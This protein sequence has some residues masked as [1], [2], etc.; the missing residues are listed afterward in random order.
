MKCIKPIRIVLEKHGNKSIFV[1]CGKCYQCLQKKRRE[2]YVRN[3]VEYLDVDSN[4][5][6]LFVTLTYD[7]SD[8]P[9]LDDG[10]PCF[11]KRDCQK[12]LDRFR[13]R[14]LRQYH[15][16]LRYFLVSEYGDTTLRPHYHALFYLSKKLEIME[17]QELLDT[18]W[19]HS[20][21]QIVW[22]QLEPGSI[23]YVCNYVLSYIFS[24]RANR[25]RPFL[26]ASRNPAIGASFLDDPVKVADAFKG[27][28][29][30][31]QVHDFRYML[32]RYYKDKIIDEDSRFDMIESYLEYLAEQKERASLERLRRGSE[33][34]L[35]ELYNL[36]QNEVKFNEIKLQ[37][38]KHK[39]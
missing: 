38:S 10:S 34:Y 8:L 28:Y 14:L 11:S 2:W 6:S 33:V 5:M 18:A 39:L 3:L 16:K 17:I 37:Q 30:G 35:T 24:S 13:K 36:H 12:F 20:P 27:D 31:F 9:R 26:L 4:P 15:T 29:L 25:M 23:S 22:Y 21:M 7:D 19:I 1:G 32:P